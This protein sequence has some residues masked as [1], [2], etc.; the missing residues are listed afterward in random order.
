MVM[1]IETEIDRRLL[2]LT[3]KQNFL[4]YIFFSLTF[5][6]LT[7]FNFETASSLSTSVFIFSII[8][9]IL[10]RKYLALEYFN[11]FPK[12]LM[13]FLSIELLNFQIKS[14]CIYNK[15]TTLILNLNL[16]FIVKH[17][18]VHIYCFNY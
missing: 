1:K 7:F 18:F 12:E 8:S 5:F 9:Q 14:H 4:T 3:V 13:F 2:V 16:M 17:N 15:N 10:S 11:T 6:N